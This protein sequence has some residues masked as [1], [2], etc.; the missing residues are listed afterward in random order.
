MQANF[1]KPNQTIPDVEISNINQI[2]LVWYCEKKMMSLLM[3]EE[4]TQEKYE[5]LYL[6]AQVFNVQWY[7]FREIW[8]DLTDTEFFYE[9]FKTKEIA[10][11]QA[12]LQQTGLRTHSEFIFKTPG[13]IEIPLLKEDTDKLHNK[14]KRLMKNDKGFLELEDLILI[15]Q[16]NA[17][18]KLKHPEKYFI[19]DKSYSET[20]QDYGVGKFITSW[21]REHAECLECEKDLMLLTTAIKKIRFL[22]EFNTG[23][24]QTWEDK[25]HPHLLTAKVHLYGMKLLEEPNCRLNQEEIQKKLDNGLLQIV[26]YEAP[27]DIQRDSKKIERLIQNGANINAR[28]DFANTTVLEKATSRKYESLFLKLLELGADV[29][30]PTND[31]LKTILNNAL[32]SHLSEKTI[33]LIIEKSNLEILNSPDELGYT[34]LHHAINGKASLS[35]IKQLLLSG[36]AITS[37]DHQYGKTP[38]IFAVE[39]GELDMVKCLLQPEC[40]NLPNHKGET[41]LMVALRSC[42]PEKAK[43]IIQAL[44]LAG[45]DLEIFKE[46]EPRKLLENAKT[47]YGPEVAMIL[48]KLKNQQQT[49]Q[50]VFN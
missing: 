20:E 50:M 9:V 7:V 22:L 44:I 14:I 24:I 46:D 3:E 4:I 11:K 49:S 43:P 18:N 19:T 37:K 31:Y 2:N 8:C 16:Q 41:P 38:L 13:R 32:S 29:N 10:L 23:P 42:S 45:S 36:L 30:I 21:S 33:L 27:R 6:F 48:D 26:S 17:N 15:S 35:V 39:K 34:A 12:L 1:F 47:L 25:I 40:I 5:E 28:D